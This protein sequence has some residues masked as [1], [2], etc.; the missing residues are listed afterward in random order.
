[1]AM[2]GGTSWIKPLKTVKDCES[3]QLSRP[4]PVVAPHHPWEFPKQTWSRLHIDYAGPFWGK[5]LLVVVNAF[6]K[7]LEV[8]T[9]VSTSS[10]VTIEKLGFIF[11]T[12]VSDNAT[13]FTS[14][15]FI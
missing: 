4:S 1:M 9:T 7:W 14:A 10:A 13:S 5:T 12:I 3:C 2:C 11:A 8:H 15:N 6:S